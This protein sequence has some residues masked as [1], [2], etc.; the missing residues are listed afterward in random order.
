[1]N[2][3][4]L[5]FRALVVAGSIATILM[6]NSCTRKNGAADATLNLIFK[7]NVKGL[8]PAGTSD[9]YSAM[10]IAQ[11]YEPLLTYNYLKRPLELEPAL[12][13]EMPKVSA[14]GLTYTIKI[15]PGVRFQ[16]DDSFKD[17]VGREV[18]AKDFIY[19]WM[20][21]ADPRNTSEAFFVIDGKIKGLNEWAKLVSQGKADYET[22]IEGLRAPD[23]QTLLIQ[24]NQPYYQLPGVLAMASMSVVPREA[25]EKYGKEFLNHPVGTGP[26]LLAKPSDWV[27]NSKMTLTKNPNYRTVTYPSV[28][29]AGDAE[30]GLLKDA[31]KKLPLV[32]HVV[33]QELTEEQPRWQNGLKG[34]SDW[35]DIPSDSFDG[36]VKGKSLEPALA[37]NGMHLDI[38]PGPDVSY[39]GFNMDDPLLGRSRELRQAISMAFDSP[40]YIKTFTN[41]R[42]IAAQGAVPPGI[43]TYS[44]D[45]RNP[46]RQY[47]VEKAKT[48][49][50]KAGYPGGKGLPELEFEM[51]SDTK[52]RQTAEYFLHA[53]E[54]IGVRVKLNSNSWVELLTKF[55]ARRAQIF[56]VGWTAVYPDPQAFFMAFYSKNASPGPNAT[57]FFNKNYDRIYE[58]ALLLPPGNKRSKLYFQ[59]RDILAE[60]CVWI[61]NLHRLNYRIVHG[62]VENFK[63]NEIALD[64]A[65]YIRINSE[66]RGQ[67]MK[68]L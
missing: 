67:L 59:L 17:G 61:F 32:D 68:T 52:S 34:N 49:L 33:I 65:K 26:F 7:V 20:R 41:G 31:G 62:W 10:V 54:K 13:A 30:A 51:L 24:L 25:V 47:D 56:A 18:V 16:N 42:G 5:A 1:M 29:A 23:S 38:S 27:R 12:A 43:E 14:D 53:M 36:A 8:D 4:S 39:V 63:A 15:R 58:A 21:M 46:Y 22:P 6:I 9:Y 66:K 37:K 2:K 50:A 60:E 44:D 3:T 11:I 64:F 45:Y 35:F 55:K 40:T 48:L 28:G 57:N 19:S